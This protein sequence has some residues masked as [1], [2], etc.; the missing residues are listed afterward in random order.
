MC[1]QLGPE[2]ETCGYSCEDHFMELDTIN[3]SWELI[4]VK[5][6]LNILEL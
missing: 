5:H 3:H 2:L 6:I 4:A 1:F